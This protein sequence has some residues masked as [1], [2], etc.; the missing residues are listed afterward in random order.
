[1]RVVIDF[2]ESLV[3]EILNFADEHEE[4]MDFEDLVSSLLSDMVN[5]K[6]TKT[7]SDDEL[8]EKIEQMILFA[9]KNRK[10][11]KS[12]KVNELYFKALDESWSKL[13]P[14]T[15]KSLGRRFRSTVDE[16]WAE[17]SEGDYV[18]EFKNRNINNAAIY[19][20]V[21]KVDL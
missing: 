21:E 14:S 19:E 9:I 2:E 12:F 3:R 7:L 18:V 15:R 4:D 16:E 13:S 8:T 10:A 17:A 5:S 1:M 20:V 11:G 6:K